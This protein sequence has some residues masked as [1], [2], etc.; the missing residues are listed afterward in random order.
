M[1]IWKTPPVSVQPELTLIRWSVF[2]TETGE[3]HFVGYCIENREGRV[4]SAICAFDPKRFCGVTQSGRA[5]KLSG[6][7]GKDPDALYV[8]SRW[9]VA[10]GVKSTRDVSD[11]LLRARRAKETRGVEHE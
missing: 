6:P 4:S 3:R 9:K 1:P 8:W 10:N 5:Y 7:A 11:E 2:E